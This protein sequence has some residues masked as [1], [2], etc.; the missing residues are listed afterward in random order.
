LTL[1]DLHRDEIH[2]RAVRDQRDLCVPTMPTLF[3]R[4]SSSAAKADGDLVHACPFSFNVLYA[5]VLAWRRT[6]GRIGKRRRINRN[7][8]LDQ[9]AHRGEILLSVDRDR[10]RQKRPSVSSTAGS[11]QASA[12]SRALIRRRQPTP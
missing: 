12:V 5:L 10:I 9:P 1:T 2:A 7:A 3:S 11:S 4:R 8:P 6:A